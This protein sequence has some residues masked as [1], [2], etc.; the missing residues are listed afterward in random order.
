M[1]NSSVKVAALTFESLIFLA[2]AYYASSVVRAVVIEDYMSDERKGLDLDTPKDAIVKVR[3]SQTA[4][5]SVISI[6]L[7]KFC[8]KGEEMK[9]Q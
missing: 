2:L 4:L 7:R 6:F 3:L 8:T 9:Q 1:K 5:L